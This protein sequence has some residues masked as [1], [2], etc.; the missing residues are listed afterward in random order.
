MGMPIVLVHGLRISG[1]MWRSQVEVLRAQGRQ[2]RAPDLPGHGAR[3]GE[4]FTLGG[5][6]EAVRDAVD[7][8]GGRALVVGLSLGGFVSIAAAAAYPGRVAG[9]VATG[10]SAKPVNA[11]AHM[12]RIPAALLGRLPDKGLAVNERL[13]RLRLPAEAAEAV[14]DGGL[15]MEAAR[16]VIEEIV[17]MDALA[18]LAS[19]PHSVWLI[20][21]ARDHF[22]IHEKLY[23]DACVDG[24]LLVVPRAG[25][26]VSLDQPEAFTTLVADAADLVAAR[27]QWGPTLNAL[28][29]PPR[30]PDSPV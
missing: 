11:L 12:Y 27:A 24:R 13:H 6:V 26:M 23:L 25:H 22:R 30:T 9:L 3:R 2:V 15:A 21:G 1:S 16:E 5:A 18:L 20:N 19:Y 28:E 14:L 10:C 29:H 8:V 17:A 4:A 7:E